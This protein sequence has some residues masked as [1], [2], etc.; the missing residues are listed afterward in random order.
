LNPGFPCEV[1]LGKD[2]A[3][4]PRLWRQIRESPLALRMLPFVVFA[5][6]TMLQGRLGP[7][8]PYWIYL[9]KSI[10]GAGVLWLVW[11][12]VSE[13]RWAMS[14][15]AVAVGVGVFVMWVGMDPYYPRLPVGGNSSSWN[16]PA[17]FGEG[18]TLAWVF[19]VMRIAAASLVV[20]PLEELFYRSLLYR[21]L[22]RPDFESV[23]LNAF[24]A[25]PFLIIAAVFGLAHREWLAGILCGLAYHALILRKGR[26]GE[27]MTA[28][29][30]TNGLLGIYV[31][32]RGAWQFW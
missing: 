9:A 10:L 12:R 22:V 3:V 6:L 21:Y 32:W 29:A 1:P 16:P 23:P 2:R 28:H 20:P 26:L 11:P 30:I 24:R 17:F 4:L 13:M 8:S 5:G 14:W 7:A 25:G 15:Q 18:S 27:A 19:I 31:V